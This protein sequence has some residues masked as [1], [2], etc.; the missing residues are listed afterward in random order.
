[1]G[2]HN[3]NTGGWLVVA[4]AMKNNDGVK[5]AAHTKKTIWIFGPR[6]VTLTESLRATIKC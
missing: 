2:P 4:D 1:M 6:A 5:N 3:H